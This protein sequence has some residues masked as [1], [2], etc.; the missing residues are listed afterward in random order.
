MPLLHFATPLDAC[1]P[2]QIE[3][4]V[5]ADAVSAWRQRHAA[6]RCRYAAMRRHGHDADAAA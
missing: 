3:Y 1:L 2:R 5:A 6:V 4:A